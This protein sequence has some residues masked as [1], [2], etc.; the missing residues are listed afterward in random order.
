MMQLPSRSFLVILATL[1]AGTAAAQ[2]YFEG[3]WRSYESSESSAAPGR[4]LVDVT[5]GDLDG[6]G[7]PDIVAGQGVYTG[8]IRVFLNAGQ[9]AG[10]TTVFDEPIFYSVQNGAWGVVT[11]DV[12]GDGDLDVAT[13]DTDI[14]GIASR[15]AILRNDGTGALS[16]AT[17][18]PAGPRGPTGITAADFD[19]DGDADIAV[20]NWGLAGFGHDISILFNDGT[21]AFG[22]PT[23]YP[24]P[25]SPFRLEAGDLDGDG[26]IDLAVAHDKDGAV[27]ILFGSGT[28]AFAPPTV[29][30]HVLPTSNTGANSAVAL[31]DADDDGDLDIG[32]TSSFAFDQSVQD[33]KLALLRNDGSGAFTTDFYYYGHPYQNVA[34]DL[35]VVDLNGDRFPDLV[36]SQFYDTGFIAFLSDGAGGYVAQEAVASADDAIAVTAADFDVDGDS[37]VVTVNRLYPLVAV[38]ENPGT[39]VFPRLPVYGDDLFVH[40]VL[41]VGDVDNDG[42][43]DVVTSHSGAISSSVNVFLGD[44]EGAFAQSYVSPDYVYGFAKLRDLDN[45]GFLDLLFVA[46]PS[47]PPYDFFTARGHGDGT[48]GTIIRWPLGTCGV[49]HP[50][51][52]DIDN[53]GDLDV[54]NTEDRG[55]PGVPD[56]GLR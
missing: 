24:V 12:D 33:G 48:F 15:I 1:A 8:G 31:L 43:I 18:Y 50:S 13:S 49:A 19:N 21:G 44:G 28:G 20:A 52:F 2:P 5:T 53:D 34:L 45:D 3:P 41:D 32:Y 7:L 38:H 26:N 35:S 36:G 37:D 22:P 56:S 42:D 27:S 46:G 25:Q 14:N 17:Y 40:Y 10:G 54:I 47:S 11:V 39:G 16:P 51:A 23:T 9:D 6:D 55:C 29:Y 30:L 4:Y